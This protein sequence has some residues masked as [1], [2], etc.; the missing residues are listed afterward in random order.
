MLILISN[1]QRLETNSPCKLANYFEGIQCRIPK[2]AYGLQL[3]FCFAVLALGLICTSIR[4]KMYTRNLEIFG[5]NLRTRF[6]KVQAFYADALWARHAIFLPC[7]VYPSFL[8]C[9]LLGIT[10][11]C[12][13]ALLSKRTLTK[14]VE[15]EDSTDKK[16]KNCYVFVGDSCKRLSLITKRSIRL[17]ARSFIIHS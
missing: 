6:V 9:P 14:R 2:T 11:T 7:T 5:N 13:P 12:A 10:F 8:F 15:E 16:K 17:F 3:A 1:S 4:G